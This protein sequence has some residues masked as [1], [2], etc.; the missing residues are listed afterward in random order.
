MGVGVPAAFI[1][2]A[3]LHS[4]LQTHYLASLPKRIPNNPYKSHNL[5]QVNESPLS[6]SFLPPPFFLVISTVPS[7]SGAGITQSGGPLAA[8]GGVAQFRARGE[9]GGL[10]IVTLPPPLVI[11]RLRSPG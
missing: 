1:P 9:G 7:L 3:P 5:G 2:G 6:L 4:P 10:L 8:V 11:S